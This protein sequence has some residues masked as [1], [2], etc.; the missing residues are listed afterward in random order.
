MLVLPVLRNPALQEGVSRSREVEELSSP[1]FWREITGTYKQHA[2]ITTQQQQ[3]WHTAA[4]AVKETLS[5]KAQHQLCLTTN[6]IIFYKL[7]MFKQVTCSIVI[8][9]NLYNLWL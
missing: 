1:G 7:I 9:L 5:K 6:T 2:G 8:K 3:E 4:N